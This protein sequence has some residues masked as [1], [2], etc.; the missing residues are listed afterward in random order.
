MFHVIGLRLQ[1]VNLQQGLGSRGLRNYFQFD[2]RITLKNFTVYSRFRGIA[3]KE[4]WVPDLEVWGL[5]GW[6]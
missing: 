5:R 2:F 1:E 4:F 3:V 6:D